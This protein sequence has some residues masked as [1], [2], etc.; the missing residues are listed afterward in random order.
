MSTTSYR[1]GA[2]AA[3]V[4]IVLT[5]SQ[6]SAAP[7]AGGAGTRVPVPEFRPGPTARVTGSADVRLTYWPDSDVRTFTF[8]AVG[9]PYSRPMPDLPGGLPTDASGT[10]R[11]A[12]RVAEQDVTVRMVARVDCLATGPGVA[13]LTAVVTEADELARDELGRRLGFSV[14]D[15]GRHGGPDRVGFSW[16]VVNAEQDEDGTWGRADVGTCLGPGPFAPVVRGDYTVRHQDLLP[17]PTG[18]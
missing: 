10:V 11:I 8:D 12:H 7:A 13:V 15:A 14:Y 6:A 18:G 1:I 16:S 4:V 9:R 5:G 3:A 2:A 17:A